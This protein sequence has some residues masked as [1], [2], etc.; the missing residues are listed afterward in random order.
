MEMNVSLTNWLIAFLPLA[1]L[2]VLMLG[3]KWGAAE[4]GPVS[5]MA[6]VAMAWFF[7]DTPVDVIGYE[8]VKGTWSAVTVLYVVWAS[9]LIYEVTH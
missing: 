8:S 3:R 9:I 7:F 4:A 5:W 2:L 1:L 6:A